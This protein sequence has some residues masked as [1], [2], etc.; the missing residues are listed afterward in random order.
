MIVNSAAKGGK[1]AAT[2]PTAVATEKVSTTCFMLSS[3]I[4]KRLHSQ[5]KT[6]GG[7]F[8][9]KPVFVVFYMIQAIDRQIKPVITTARSPAAIAEPIKSFSSLS[10]PIENLLSVNIYS[11]KFRG[12]SR[13]LCMRSSKSSRMTLSS[14]FI[15]LRL[16]FTLSSRA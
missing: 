16:S 1:S 8:Q 7:C 9:I 10:L 15:S 12:L 11:S 2:V 3:I 14:L 13:I 6:L 5:M 4:F